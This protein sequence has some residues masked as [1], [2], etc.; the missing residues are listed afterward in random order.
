ML[1][2][3]PSGGTEQR[4][5]YEPGFEG[6]GWSGDVLQGILSVNMMFGTMR[7][8]GATKGV[9]V[10]W[11]EG[12][13]QGP[14]LGMPRL[15]SWNIEQKA[16]GME[17]ELPV[18]HEKTWGKLCPA[19]TEEEYKEEG[20]T[21]V[22]NVLISQVQRGLRTDHCIWP[23]G[24]HWRTSQ[25]QWWLG[26]EQVPE[27]LGGVELDTHKDNSFEYCKEL[28]RNEAVII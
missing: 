10:D 2:R 6:V 21:M 14:C 13:I 23:P 24:G 26:E 4:V 25:N 27:M 5:E 15:G 17:K 22:S 28:C 8:N 12:R 3:N 18:N 1:L 19:S 16:V 20:T 9:S 7:E 11:R